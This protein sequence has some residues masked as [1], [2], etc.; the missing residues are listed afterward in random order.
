MKEAVLITGASRGIGRATAELFA[1]RGYPVI[2]NYNHSRDSAFELA[3]KINI[4][5][6]VAMAVKAD[7]SDR[8]EV[9]RMFD[10]IYSELGGVGILINNAAVARQSLF[11]DIEY[12]EW[13]ETF[14]INVDGMFHCTQLALKNMLHNHSGCIVNISSMW[15]QVGA[16]CEVLYSATKSAVIGMTKALAKELGPSGIRV[17]C[18]APGVIDTDMNSSLTAEDMD[19]LR[20]E[21]PLM[22]IGSSRDVANAIY[23]LCS[24]SASFIT[25]QVICPNGGYII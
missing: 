11:T 15:G 6:G 18:V 10:E 1:E 12:S 23:Y 13:R 5:G 21:T 4:S 22:K 24:E 14:A 19:L 17:N 3:R 7:V 2:I 20:D 16:S 25:G 8:S 9:E